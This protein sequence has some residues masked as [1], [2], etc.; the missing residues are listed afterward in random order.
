MWT[1]VVRP[2]KY[3]Q[4]KNLNQIWDFESFVFWSKFRF[5]GVG[6]GRFSQCFFLF[7]RCQPS[8]PQPAHHH[9]YRRKASCGHVKAHCD[10]LNVSE[11]NYETILI[12]PQPAKLL[13]VLSKSYQVWQKW[14]SLNSSLLLQ[15]LAQGGN[16]FWRKI[17]NSSAFNSDEK[18]LQTKYEL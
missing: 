5:W 16:L 11:V 17:F 1:K 8:T 18:F 4:K 12:S 3:F 14:F 9:H 13:R 15:K 6:L 7:F 10:L 2:K